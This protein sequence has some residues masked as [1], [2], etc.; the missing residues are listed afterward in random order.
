MI[1]TAKTA[2]GSWN[3]MKAALYA[4]YSTFFAARMITTRSPSWFMAT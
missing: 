2:C 1:D 4:V 3:M